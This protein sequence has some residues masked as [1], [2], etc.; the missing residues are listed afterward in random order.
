M[1]HRD[2]LPLG[3]WLWTWESQDR[4][5]HSRFQSFMPKAIFA[6]VPGL[7][8]AMVISAMALLNSGEV[9]WVEDP[10]YQQTRR[11]L[12]LAGAKIVPKPLDNQGIVIARSPREPLPRIIY[13]TPSHQFPLG[14][15]MSFQR[16]TGF[17][18]FARSPHA[19]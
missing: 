2:S 9:A 4:R 17:L 15:T 16:R 1:A 3:F 11:V 5:L 14:V 10:C 6:Q 13:V 8:Q 7:E 18:G 12:T 19:F